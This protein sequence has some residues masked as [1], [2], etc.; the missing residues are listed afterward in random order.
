MRSC[1]YQWLLGMAVILHGY[2]AAYAEVIECKSDQKARTTCTIR[3]NR[4]GTYRLQ[5][6]AYVTDGH[7]S[8]TVSVDIYLDGKHCGGLGKYFANGNGEVSATCNVALDRSRSYSVEVI[9]G[10]NRANAAG[11]KLILYYPN[12]YTD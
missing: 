10:N 5:G 2:S 8:P 7:S 9:G 11:A 1:L 3:P 4:S 12:T 6:T